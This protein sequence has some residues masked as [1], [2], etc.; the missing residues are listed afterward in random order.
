MIGMLTG[1]V[2]EID[3]DTAIIDVGGIGFELRMPA[4]DLAAMHGGQQARVYTALSVSQD[5]V[6]LFGFLAKSSRSLFA[7]LQKVSGI[8]P[9]VALS[10]L[11]TLT[12]GQLAQAVSEG[13][14]AAL[15]RAPGLGKKGAQK[16]ILELA[17]KLDL[18]EIAT[19]ASKGAS[20]RDPALEQCVQGLVSLGWQQRDAESAVAAVC[21]EENIT[22]PL[23]AGDVP[24]VLKL[25]LASLD[26]GR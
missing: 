1:A 14:A 9:K 4:S 5:A 3:A 15:S 22:L 26:R 20:R 17:G 8:G 13:D 10:I 7:Q 23:A 6:T 12:P 16:I 11:S 24:H 25:A 2:A 19:G 21:D 18:G